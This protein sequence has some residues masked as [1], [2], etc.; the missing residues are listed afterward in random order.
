MM[1]NVTEVVTFR[2]N[3]LFAQT[4]VDYNNF[5]KSRLTDQ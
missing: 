4:I 2:T 1:R 3:I 5:Y